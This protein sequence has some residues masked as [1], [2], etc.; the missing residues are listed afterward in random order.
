MSDSEEE[1]Y[2]YNGVIIRDKYVIIDKIGNGSYGTV[3]LVQNIDTNQKF[4]IKKSN[5]EKCESFDREIKMLNILSK[6]KEKNKINKN[7]SYTIDMIDHFI[8]KDFENNKQHLD[9]YYIVFEYKQKKSLYEYFERVEKSINEKYAKAIFYKIAKGVEEIHGARICHLDLK[10]DNIL[11]DENYKPIICDFGFAC[12][13]SNNLDRKRGTLGYIAPELFC[14]N[15]Y[16]G[17]Q[18]D[19]FSLGAILLKMLTGKEIF[20]NKEGFIQ[21]KNDGNKTYIDKYYIDKYYKYIQDNNIDKYWEEIGVSTMNL[22]KDFKN[23]CSSMINSNPDERPT[24]SQI[25]AHPWLSEYINLTDKQKFD[26]D[27]EI[28]KKEFEKREELMKEKNE[29]NEVDY[30]EE[31]EKEEFKL[32]ESKSIGKSLQADDKQSYKLKT[33]EEDKLDRKYYFKINGN[34]NP[35]YYMKALADKL[36][37]IKKDNDYREFDIIP[38]DDYSKLVILF[39]NNDKEIPEELKNIGFNDYDDYAKIFGLLDLT[40][41]IKMFKSKNGYLIRVIK[42]GGN[43]EDFNEYL[44]IIM[45]L[46]KSTFKK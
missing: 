43:A 34:L 22:K 38:N 17:F 29:E 12:I 37:G 5:R 8:G 14:K 24:I 10:L 45:K 31:D 11:L 35:K 13:N 4:V 32:D 30:N 46:I 6:Y 21:K 28:K 19:I 15:Q 27:M 39:E 42:K 16:N 36:K 40:I 33:L 9:K 7:N 23:L 3:Y 25:L 2:N 20:D 26:L 18:A 1:D 41:Q 44:E